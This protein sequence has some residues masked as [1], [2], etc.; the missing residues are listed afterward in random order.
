M[1]G[2]DYLRRLRRGP[3][4]EFVVMSVTL[5]LTVL[6]D[7]MTAIAVG[8]ILSSFVNSRWLAERRFKVHKQLAGAAEL[9]L[10]TFY[11]K[12]LLRTVDDRVAVTLLRGS[13]SYASARELARRDTQPAAP[14]NVVIYDFSHSTYIDESVALT[15]RELIDLTQKR[16]RQVIVAGLHGYAL[17]ALDRVGALDQVPRAYRFDQRKAAIE[18]AVAYCL[19][20][21]QSIGKLPS[22]NSDN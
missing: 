12:A 11:K 3:R 22:D 15:V 7:P 1:I 6:V 13:F 21:D 17:K 2:W 18:S 5:G 9:D 8:I 4:V 14:G 20:S 16:N 10:L 19:A